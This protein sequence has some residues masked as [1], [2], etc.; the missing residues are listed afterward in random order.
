GQLK[1]APE[2]SE[3]RVLDKMAKAGADLL[4]EF[5]NRF[6]TY[7]AQA[8]KKQY[9]TYY[10][11]AAHPG[12]SEEDMRALRSFAIR[13]LRIYPEQVQIFTP[14]PSTYSSLMYYTEID[15]FTMESLFVEKL[16]KQKDVQKNILVAKPRTSAT[17]RKRKNG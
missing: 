9:L 4:L 7:S 8:G 5:K 13:E 6:D 12:C 10:F 14:T 16:Q 11:I 3:K 17:K 1:I 2:H 15:P